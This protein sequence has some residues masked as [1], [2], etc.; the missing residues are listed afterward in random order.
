[1]KIV[2]FATVAATLISISPAAAGTTNEIRAQIY[3]KNRGSYERARVICLA[4]GIS[5]QTYEQKHPEEF[6]VSESLR[7]NYP[8]FYAQGVERGTIEINNMLSDD[9][10]MRRI[11]CRGYE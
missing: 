7:I 11:I 3:G 6:K 9:V 2:Y 4:D 10:E 5:L 8:G 1:M